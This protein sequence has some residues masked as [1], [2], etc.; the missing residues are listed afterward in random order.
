MEYRIQVDYDKDN[1]AASFDCPLCYSEY[2]LPYA[3]P[4]R[5]EPSPPPDWVTR[6]HFEGERGPCAELARL[7]M[8]P[9][10]TVAGTTVKL[11]LI[12][13]GTDHEC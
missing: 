5:V 10:Y 13:S 11:D 8:T 1:L 6:Q 7:N 12:P 4:D 2:E 3:A 9:E